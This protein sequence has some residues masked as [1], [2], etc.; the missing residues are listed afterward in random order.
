MGV[1]AEHCGG[2][3]AATGAHM[4]TSLDHLKTPG[5][6]TES[7]ASPGKGRRGLGFLLLVASTLT[8]S[9]MSTLVRFAK[10][11]DGL[12]S[13][14]VTLVRFTVGAAVVVAIARATGRG[15]RMGNLRLLAARGA[16]G[17]AAVTI[18]F[19]S[20]TN[21]GLAKGTI[22]FSTFPLWA[23]LLAFLFLREPLRLRLAAAMLAAFCGLYLIVVPPE[24]LS[25]ISTRDLVALAGGVCGGG[26][27]V[28]VRRLRATESSLVIFLSQCLFGMAVVAWPAV[29]EPPPLD[30]VAWAVLLAVGLAASAGQLLMTSAYK[31][32]GVSESAPVNMLTPVWNVALGA[33]VFHEAVSARGY[34]GA[35]LVLAA[36]TYATLPR[37]G[38]QGRRAREQAGTVPSEG[39][40]PH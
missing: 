37:G 12:T 9:L 40:R 21:I 19:Y 26:A 6:P 25:G 30:P 33:L 7:A 38:P 3:A 13:Y 16:L 5:E 8:L 11:V 18:Y 28:T 1:V 34:A 14:S 36:C 27:I 20:I 15:L 32:V 22:L 24:G 35:L 2:A 4:P 17:A 23:G 29:A 10:T 31:Y 39:A